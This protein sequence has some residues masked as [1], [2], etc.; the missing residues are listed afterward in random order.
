MNGKN[1]LDLTKGSIQ[2][3]ILLFALPLLGS[4]LIQQLYNTVDLLFVGNWLGKNAYA[5]V[6]ASSLIVTCLVG[7][8]T[9]M[10]VGANVVIA[11][12]IGLDSRKKIQDSVHTA[13]GLSLVGGSVLMIIGLLGA[14]CFL[15]WM[16]T[17]PEILQEAAAYLRIYFLSLISI[18]LYNMISGILRAM[19]NSR[20]PMMIQ[21]IG[22]IVNVAADAILIGSFRTVEAA[23]WAT[24]VS[25]TLAA[26]LAL[27]YLAKRGE[28]CM[29]HWKKIRISPGILK[30][31]IKVGIPSG[32]QNLVI[33]LSNIFAQY[34]INSLGVDSIGAF[35]TYFKVELLLYYPIV[36]LGQAMTT[37][38]GQ[39]MGAGEPERVK[40]GVRICIT[41]GILLT[42]A[43]AALLL[44][45]GRSVF[46]LFNG[47][48]NVLANGLKVI[49]ITFPFYWLYVILE[50]LADTIRGAGKAIMPMLIIL[51]NICLLR[52]VLL[53]AI[54]SQWKDIRGIAVTYPITWLATAV[55]MS[56]YYKKGIWL[57]R[58]GIPGDG[59][60]QQLEKP[61][62][63]AKKTT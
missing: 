35:T 22:G 16:N 49:F 14:P 26:A 55:C 2:K 36:A 62:F 45:S 17:E 38:T 37:F 4:S 18:I 28:K 58:S 6:G 1:N 20:V 9:G 48:E 12:A 46:R 8:F 10:S 7:F 29:V 21:L 32:T 43:T 54:M 60:D 61:L 15:R 3:N 63:S 51:G 56:V 41:M 31:I 57:K 23:A 42:A 50:V 34:H 24:M 39:N 5:A 59:V 47:D 19:G 44:L 52:T 13:I 30:E 40:K 11:Q 33:T 53:F 27:A 25:Q